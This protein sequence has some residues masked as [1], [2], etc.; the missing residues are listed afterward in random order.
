MN[1]R[2]SRFE[3]ATKARQRLT[4]VRWT[5]VAFSLLVF[6]GCG[7]LVWPIF[8]FLVPAPH[9][10]GY[11]A[12]ISAIDGHEVRVVRAVLETGV[13]PNAFP[14]S[15][16]ARAREEDITP[17][18]E[19]VVIGNPAVVKLL[20]EFGANP[21]VGD[22]WHSSPLAAAA[23][24]DRVDLLAV[25]LNGKDKVNRDVCTDALWSAAVNGHAKCV[26]LLLNNGAN[27]NISYPNNGTLLSVVKNGNGDPEIIQQLQEAGAK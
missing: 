6:A 3:T 8:V 2:N 1:Y 22:G 9:P 13:E 27:P 18:N 4:V 15:D 5:Y 14:D 23:E 11:D 25:L 19:A 26:E 24:N 7:S 12:L 17:L 21:N 20:L 10:G 16:W